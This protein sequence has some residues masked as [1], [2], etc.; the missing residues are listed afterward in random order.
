MTNAQL[1]GLDASRDLDVELVESVRQMQ[2]REGTVVHL[3]AN[4][5]RQ[6]SRNPRGTRA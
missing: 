1:G 2:R 6:K 3:P 4:A 5:A